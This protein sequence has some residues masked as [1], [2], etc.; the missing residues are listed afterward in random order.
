MRGAVLYGVL[1]GSRISVHMTKDAMRFLDET[2]K[3]IYIGMELYFTYFM[4][5]KVRITEEKP[6]AEVAKITDNI[7]IS[8]QSLQSKRGKMKDLKGDDSD[9]EKMPIKRKGALIPKYILVDRK[10][11]KWVGDFTWKSGNAHLRPLILNH[12]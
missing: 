6:K 1:D 9:L 8:F 2:G 5:K 7:F 10:K 3:T 4:R 12:N 11:N